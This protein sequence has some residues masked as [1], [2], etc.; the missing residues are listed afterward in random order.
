MTVFVAVREPAAVTGKLGLLSLKLGDELT[1]TGT[2]APT[3]AE[4]DT[5]E[6]DPWGTTVTANVR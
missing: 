6:P 3:A 5:L 4:P 1:R 2:K